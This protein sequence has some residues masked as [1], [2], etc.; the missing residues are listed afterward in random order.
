M[1]SDRPLRKW[2]L[3]RRA[4]G[5]LALSALGIALI[6]PLVVVFCCFFYFR[7]MPLRDMLLIGAVLAALLFLGLMV[8]FLLPVFRGLALLTR[9]ERMFGVSFRAAGLRWP[10]SGGDWMLLCGTNGLYAFYRG[11]LVKAGTEG[12]VGRRY[13]MLVTDCTGKQHTVYGSP[14]EIGALREWIERTSEPVSGK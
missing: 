5:Q 8:F 14:E 12:M 4:T 1:K 3:V 9:Q 11:F 6:V 10:D 7:G 2:S 13:A